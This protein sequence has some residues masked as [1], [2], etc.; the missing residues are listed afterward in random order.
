MPA[1]ADISDTGKVP[2]IGVASMKSRGRVAAETI[3]T[4]RKQ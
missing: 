2:Y 4:G 3:V 1:G